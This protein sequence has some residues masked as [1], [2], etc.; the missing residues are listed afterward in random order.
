MEKKISRAIRLLQSFAQIDEV[1][2]CYS[3]GKDSEVILELAKM[4]GI[5]FRAIYRNT[6]IDPC[7]TIA[8]VRRK[9]VEIRQPK[10]SF[11]EI[12]EKHGLPTRRAR[13]CCGYLKEYKILSKAVQGVRRCESVKRKARYKSSD[14]IVCRIY[15]AKKNHVNV[16]LP[17]LNWSDDDVAQFIELRGIKCH[18]LYYEDGR[19]IVERRLGCLGCPLRVDNGVG[20]YV[21]YP[22]FFYQVVKRAKKWWDTHPNTRSREK[23]GD[24]YGLIAHN[25]FYKSYSDWA[26]ADKSMF[27]QPAW[28]ETLQDYFGVE[29]P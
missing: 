22:K 11:F 26:I 3:G 10:K 29:L 9:G 25:L 18:S 21:R 23:F 13:F 19:F 17:I 7:G 14:P 20:D 6:T 2:L 1:E 15:G 16:C 27:G 28:K 12:V 5:K 4:A 8:H 24:I